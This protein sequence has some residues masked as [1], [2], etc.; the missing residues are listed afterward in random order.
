[1]WILTGIYGHPEEE[2]KSETW[3]LMRHLHA[4]A[5]LP[6][7]CLGDFNEI[8]SFDE[9]N[10]GNLRPMG[11]MMKFRQTLLHCGLVDLG[12]NGYRFTW[13]NGKGG[14][15]F[16][17]ERLDRVVATSEWRE[18]FPRTKVRRIPTSY[19]NHDPILM[20]MNPPTQPKKQRHKI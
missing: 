19:S 17:E 3:R 16:V 8:L 9:K 2:R 18:M 12:F 11:A 10:G 7:V 5:S 1:M 15:A 6:C 4:R 20:D 14:A 13:R